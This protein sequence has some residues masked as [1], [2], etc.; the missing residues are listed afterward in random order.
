M[1]YVRS[2]RA[3]NRLVYNVHRWTHRNS[4]PVGVASD[5]LRSSFM[6]ITQKQFSP[7]LDCVNLLGVTLKSTNWRELL[8]R[9]EITGHIPS[10][11][12]SSRAIADNPSHPNSLAVFAPTSPLKTYVNRHLPPGGYPKICNVQTTRKGVLLL[13][14]L[15]L[16]ITLE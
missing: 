3:M 9:S 13:T 14:M 15:K 6:R 5:Q 4:H 1:P 7:H 8:V 11:S 2:S 16:G 10:F 12:P